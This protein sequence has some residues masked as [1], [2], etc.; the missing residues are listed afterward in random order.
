M[1]I[2]AIQRKMHSL[3]AQSSPDQ[4]D[5]IKQ[6][7]VQ[8]HATITNWLRLEAF[9]QHGFRAQ[10]IVSYLSQVEAILSYAGHKGRSAAIAGRST[11]ASTP[12][13]S[14]PASDSATSVVR[15]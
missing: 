12:A 15:D 4:I 5:A 7:V 14:M 1:E 9:T 2:E 13:A 11:Y 6:E 3:N 10:Y 8:L